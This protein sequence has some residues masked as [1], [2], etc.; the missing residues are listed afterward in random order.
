MKITFQQFETEEIFVML[1]QC[2]DYTLTNESFLTVLK[3][4]DNADELAAIKEMVDMDIARQRSKDTGGDDGQ[5]D[6]CLQQKVKKI[7]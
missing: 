3:T 6:Y 5:Y 7:L 2:K 4:S 1:F